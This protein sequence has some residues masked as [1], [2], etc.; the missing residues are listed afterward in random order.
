LDDSLSRAGITVN[1][2]S[3]HASSTLHRVLT[4]TDGNQAG[5]VR[6]QVLQ[7]GGQA[8]CLSDDACHGGVILC[9]MT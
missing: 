3:D 8:K 9:V 2:V 6:R 1:E 5:L 4:A 7:A